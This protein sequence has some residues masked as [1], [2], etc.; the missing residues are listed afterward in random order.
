MRKLIH[1]KFELDLSQFKLSDTEENNWFSDSFFAKYSFPFEID[2]TAEWDVVFGFISFYNTSPETYY[3]VKY[4]DNNKIEDAV[5]VIESAKDKMS[6]VLRFGLEQFPNW[7]TKLADLPLDNFTLPTGTT[8]YQH[9]ETVISKSWPEVNYNFPQVY[10]DKYKDDGFFEHFEGIVNNRKDSVFL[11]NYVD[12]AN[13]TSYNINVMQPLPYWL[14]ILQKGFDQSG[15]QLSGQIVDDQ[16]IKKATIF[17][18]GDYFKKNTLETINFA[19]N[20]KD[21]VSYDSENNRNFYDKTIALPFLKGDYRLTGKVNIISGKNWETVKI[22][23]NGVVVWEES[24]KNF[25]LEF[26]EHEVGVTFSL[27]ESNSNTIQFYSTQQHIGDSDDDIINVDID[28][29]FLRDSN[30]EIIPTVVNDNK[31]DLTKSVPDLTFG[32]FVSVVKN[33]FNYDLTIEGKKAI[34]NK[35]ENEINYQDTLDFQFTEVKYPLIKYNQGVSFLLK[36]KEI[37]NKNYS[38]KAVYQNIKGFT[39]TG[40]KTDENT[41]TIEIDALPLPL[42]TVN[43]VTTAY[44]LESSDSKVYLVPYLGQN[45]NKNVTEDVENYLIPS[46]HLNYF[47]KWFDFRIQSR[48]FNWSFTAFNESIDKLKTKTKIYAYKRFH[49]I[50]TINRT[51][52]KP[53]LF[54]VDL[55]TDTLP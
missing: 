47:K 40:Y 49:I 51:E 5:F 26:E 44:A 3:E 50:K 4:F 9:A 29:V 28:T 31:I 24:D 33:W 36:F 22:L 30:N 14:H 25:L 2:L 43:G 12:V 45:N 52:I 46:V 38:F 7:D 17:F 19:V 41:K 35:I 13:E 10:T 27:E 37:D 16:N 1:S 20:R 53:N 54:E 34:M 11:K 32:Y 6:C 21:F 15:Y 8:I 55:E 39:N 18:Y 23:V 42:K 48:G